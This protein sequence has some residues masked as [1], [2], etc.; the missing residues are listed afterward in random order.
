MYKWALFILFCLACTL[1]VGLLLFNLPAKQTAVAEEPAIVIPDKSVDT[2]AAESVYKS[3]CVSCHGDQLQGSLGPNLTTIGGS[4]SKEKIYKQIIK[5][6]NG[7]PGFEG[8][9]TEDEIVNL[10]NWLAAKK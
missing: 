6:G 9:L 7:M 1:S 4:V 2:K 8:K 3:N 5:G 10:S